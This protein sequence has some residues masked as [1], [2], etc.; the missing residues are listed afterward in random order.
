MKL[1]VSMKVMK[2]EPQRGGSY[3]HCTESSKDKYPDKE[4]L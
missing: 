4:G 2:D 1:P 3:L